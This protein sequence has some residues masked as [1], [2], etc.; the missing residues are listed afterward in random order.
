MNDL[1]LQFATCAKP[2]QQRREEKKPPAKTERD[3]RLYFAG[4]K[5]HQRRNTPTVSRTENVPKYRKYI[6]FTHT[7]L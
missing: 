3:G 5:I 7:A 6:L 4:T 1:S 2:V